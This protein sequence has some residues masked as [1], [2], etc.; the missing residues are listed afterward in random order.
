MILAFSVC[1]KKKYLH[2]PGLFFCVWKTRN[3]CM[4]LAFSVSEKQEMPALV[5][6]FLFL[7]TRNVCIILAFSVC[8][9]HW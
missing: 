8:G 5:W 9:K 6:P 4:I 3:V 2:Y 7:K 1:E